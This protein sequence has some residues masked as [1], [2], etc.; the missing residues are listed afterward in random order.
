MTKPGSTL[1]AVHLD[2]S[3]TLRPVLP[4]IRAGLVELLD[5][6]PTDGLSVVVSTGDDLTRSLSDGSHP[7]AV[8]V[9]PSAAVA[10]LPD[11]LRTRTG[12]DLR[13]G[14]T[15]LLDAVGEELAGRPESERPERVVVLLVGEA[16][17]GDTTALRERIEH[18]RTTYDWE[19]ALVD[20]TTGTI[21]A[22]RVTA[23]VGTAAATD[24]P[25][26]GAAP[27]A[28]AERPD[29][30]AAA[31]RFGIPAG[32]TITAGPGVDGVAAAMTAASGFVRRALATP[33]R[34]PVVGFTDNERAAA[35]VA[36]TR[37]AWRRILR[38]P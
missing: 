5:A 29:A 33:S 3:S 34:E 23:P 2:R 35:D 13:I 9:V 8:Q 25:A 26:D 22:A 18:Q 20:V 10:M 21:P 32:A 28:V 37:P 38:L 6:Q 16:G 31:A 14:A 19:F 15:R 7:P 12:P 11:R 30:P 27:V 17:V 36:D 24:A 1:L 4:A